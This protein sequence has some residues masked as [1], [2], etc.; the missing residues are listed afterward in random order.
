[1]TM[2]Q[3][4]FIASFFAGMLLGFGAPE[5]KEEALKCVADG[6]KA[7]WLGG[8]GNPNACNAI[9]FDFGWPHVAG[10]CKCPNNVSVR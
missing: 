5:L 2:L 7:V 4:P 3:F 9:E 10:S 1:M 8:G 6:C